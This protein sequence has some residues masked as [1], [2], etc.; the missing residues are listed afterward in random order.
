LYLH[1][2]PFFVEKHDYLFFDIEKEFLVKTQT[3]INLAY[4][5]YTST[6]IYNKNRE[7][8]ALLL[9]SVKTN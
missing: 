5:T 2:K 1:Y 8:L 3:K 9:F 6:P 4:S 7:L